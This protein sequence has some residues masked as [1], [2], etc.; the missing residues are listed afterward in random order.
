MLSPLLLALF[1]ASPGP[2]GLRLPFYDW[3]ACPFECCTYRQWTANAPTAVLNARRG[4]APAAFQ[5]KAG[6]TVEGLTGVVVTTRAGTA[7]VFRATTLGE[8]QIKVSPGDQ[9]LLLHYQGEGYWKFWFR[10]H[11]SSD[12]LAD[13]NDQAPDSELD[14]RIVT[15]PLTVWW[16]KV[17]NSRGK[18]GWTEQTDHF[19]HM[20]ACE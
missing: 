19:D 18:E 13:I 2:A 15:H 17:R 8:R 4:N 12:Q 3:G 10:G 6:D 16:V 14:L 1:L 9:L 5:L 11:I 20:D 7:K